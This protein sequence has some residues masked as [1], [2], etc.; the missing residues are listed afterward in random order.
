MTPKSTA[1]SEDTA[2]ENISTARSTRISPDRG[3]SVGASA[4]RAATPHASEQRAEDSSRDTHQQR[5]DKNLP[6]DI[7][8]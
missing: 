6:H 8:T 2:S 1:V 7:H 4:T 5:F 3:N